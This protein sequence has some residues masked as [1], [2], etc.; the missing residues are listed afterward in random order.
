MLCLLRYFMLSI[1]VDLISVVFVLIR[2]GG[3]AT[4]LNES[5]VYIV[6]EL[7]FVTFGSP[8]IYAA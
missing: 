8:S 1:Y 6:F 2:H 5:F 7:M 4:V 3:C